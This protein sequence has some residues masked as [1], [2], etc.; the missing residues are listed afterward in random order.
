MDARMIEAARAVLAAHGQND[1][2]KA[3]ASGVAL[4]H[5]VLGDA[6]GTAQEERFTFAVE[7][8]GAE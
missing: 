6:E 7:E 3:A 5:L 2:P 1:T 4:A 8:P